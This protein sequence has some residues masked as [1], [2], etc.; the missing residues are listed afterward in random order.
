LGYAKPQS[1]FQLFVR[2]CS[3]TFFCA[4]KNASH[5][6][7]SGA[8]KLRIQPGT[9]SEIKIKKISKMVNEILKILNTYYR[10]YTLE[11]KMKKNVFYSVCILGA[12]CMLLINCGLT[13]PIQGTFTKI[14]NGEAE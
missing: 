10:I 3:T 5:F 1:G 14:Y 6:S 2:F 9:L 11:V 4:R 13:K 7:L 12:F 8:K